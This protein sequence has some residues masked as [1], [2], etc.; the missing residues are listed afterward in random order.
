MLAR[1]YMAR[2]DVAYTVRS[3]ALHVW[4]TLVT[5]TPKTLTE[6]LP[7]LMSLVIQGLATGDDD[8]GQMAARCLGELVRKMG[9]RVLA[10]IL[11]ILKSGMKSEESSTRAGVCNGLR[12]VMENST[13]HQLAE[14]LAELLP[15]VQEAL[16]DEDPEV[17]AAAGG[18]H[19]CPGVR[20]WP[21]AA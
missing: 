3:A 10:Q 16:C 21:D 15:A 11:P 8:R 2:S 7:A 4:K 13:R 1:I 19:R 12:E 14:H 9:D 17:R 6:L 20:V 5:N 18:S